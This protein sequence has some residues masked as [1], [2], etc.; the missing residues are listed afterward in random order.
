VSPSYP[1]GHFVTLHEIL[2]QNHLLLFDLAYNRIPRA[3]FQEALKQK[4]EKP[5]T[6]DSSVGKI[7]TVNALFL[8]DLTEEAD[9]P[10]HY[11][12]VPPSVSLDKILKAMAVYELHGLND[13]DTAVRFGERLGER[14]DVEHAIALLADSKCRQPD[15]VDPIELLRQHVRNLEGSTSWRLTAPLRGLKSLLGG[16]RPRK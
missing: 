11:P 9:R 3:T 13:I 16:A 15:G 12:Q 1:K 4:G 10:H 7:S 6:D 2:L 5:V 8:R 14:I